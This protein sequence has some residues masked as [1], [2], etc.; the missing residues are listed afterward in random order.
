MKKKNVF[1]VIFIILLLVMAIWIFY[2]FM[3]NSRTYVLNLPQL[4]KLESI[5]LE[6]DTTVKTISENEEIEDILNV[7]K[8]NGRTTKSESI[9][10]SPVNT[11]SKIRVNFHF[12]ESGTST[13]FV[14]EKNDK[15]Y[16]EQ[17]YNGIYRISMDEYNSIEKYVM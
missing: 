2:H 1:I 11:S 3:N 10:D 16:I 14:Y 7:L 9:Q 5:S 6:K 12:K 15:Y 13:V 17:P 4:E 8:G